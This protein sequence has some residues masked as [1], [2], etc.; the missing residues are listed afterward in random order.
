MAPALKKVKITKAA[1]AKEV[2]SLKLKITALEEEAKHLRSKHK[3]VK[4]TLAQIKDLEDELAQYEKMDI[5][6]PEENTE[7]GPELL[8]Q[9]PKL[10]ELELLQQQRRQLD[11][12]E[13]EV[14]RRMGSEPQESS[15]FVS[16]DDVSG[17]ESDVVIPVETSGSLFG[18]T[19]PD[20]KDLCFTKRGRSYYIIYQR[21]PDRGNRV[22][23]A[24]RASLRTCEDLELERVV[25]QRPKPGT[26]E[27]TGIQG[28]VVAPGCDYQVLLR[29]NWKVEDKMGVPTTK[30][31]WF[32]VKIQYT[33]NGV[34]NK[35]GNPKKKTA[36]LSRSALSKIYPEGHGILALDEDL[37]LN[38]KVVWK[39]DTPIQKLDLAILRAY[40]KNQEDFGTPSSRAR[41]SRSPTV[42]RYDTPA[43]N[44]TRV[45]KASSASAK[46]KNA[47][48][49]AFAAPASRNS[50]P[51]GAAKSTKAIDEQYAEFLAWRKAT[52]QGDPPMH[53]DMVA[54]RAAMFGKHASVKE[55]EEEE[56]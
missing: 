48:T 26:F 2:K 5:D 12:Y 56:L 3:A 23:E 11:E 25:D 39:E 13:A 16:S 53:A 41:S 18:I 19:P 50:N 51:L 52:A 42:Q 37:C 46:G 4:P 21:G 1:R 24:R 30:Y 31:P 22:Y 49:V 54:N 17:Y 55:E 9:E 35:D 38:G 45:D 15:L 34:F 32:Q 47:K 33:E 36:F 44:A 14:R 29:K 40:I 20:G 7:Q 8:E 43:L 10:S 6:D 28:V 27:L